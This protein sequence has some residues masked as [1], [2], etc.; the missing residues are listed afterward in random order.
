MMQA[1]KT[2]GSLFEVFADDT[3]SV[4]VPFEKGRDIIAALSTE[5][6]KHDLSYVKFLLNQGKEYS[7]SV[8]S[9]QMDKLLKSGSIISLCDGRVYAL[10]E[11]NYGKYTGLQVEPVEKEE[12]E[13]STQIL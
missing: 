9:W 10:L 4:I 11:D 13:W 7:V 8:Y 5:R 2:A 1:F 12:S 3:N 6:A